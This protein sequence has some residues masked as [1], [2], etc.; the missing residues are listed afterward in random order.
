MYGKL[1]GATQFC[2]DYYSEGNSAAPQEKQEV[3]S[4]AAYLLP[5]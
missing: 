3:R 4:L 2:I 5:T 1:L